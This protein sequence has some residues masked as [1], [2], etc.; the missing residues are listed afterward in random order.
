[1]DGTLADAVAEG[2]TRIE[3]LARKEGWTE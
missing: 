1:V 2:V 3:A